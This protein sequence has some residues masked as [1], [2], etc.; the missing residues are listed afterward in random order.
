L[1]VAA[2]EQITVAF[3]M[4]DA[5]EVR[6]ASL[7]KELCSYAPRQSGCKALQAHY[8][9]GALTSVAILAELGGGRPPKDRVAAPHFPQREHHPTAI[10]SPTRDQPRSR[11][12]ISMGARAQPT[13]YQ[14]PQPPS[15]EA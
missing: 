11:T 6:V 5:I 8:G 10:M 15:R 1:P 2:R 3:G 12:E 7:D 14:Q 4:I 9:I 13:K